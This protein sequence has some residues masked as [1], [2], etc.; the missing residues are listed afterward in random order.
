MPDSADT[1]FNQAAKLIEQRR[2]HPRGPSPVSRLIP[3]LLAAT[4]VAAQQA[5]QGMAAAWQQAGGVEWSGLTRPGSLRRGQLEIFVPDSMVLQQ[6]N[7]QSARLL[8]ALR[9]ALPQSRVRGLRFRVD[10][11]RFGT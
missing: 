11:T 9:Q 7:F 6:I 4:G 8:E 3:R 10:P 2:I 5:D 1:E